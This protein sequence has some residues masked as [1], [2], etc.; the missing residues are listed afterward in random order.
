MKKVNIRKTKTWERKS[1]WMFPLV[2]F[3]FWVWFTAN[4]FAGPY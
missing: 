1:D 3:V 2:F 4:F